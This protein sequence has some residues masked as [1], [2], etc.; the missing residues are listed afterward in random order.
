MQVG[1][2]AKSGLGFG[3]TACILEQSP[4]CDLSPEL[5]RDEVDDCLPVGQRPLDI[6]LFLRRPRQGLPPAWLIRLGGG[7][8]TENG[9]CRRKPML[10]HQ[11][12]RKLV[13]R[14]RRWPGE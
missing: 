8:P 10:C 13:E 9:C 2:I 6:T 4:E 11:S 1:Q 5:P 12:L 14:L 3:Q 7:E